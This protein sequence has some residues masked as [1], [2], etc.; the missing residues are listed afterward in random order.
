MTLAIEVRSA[1]VLRM[2]RRLLLLIALAACG[3]GA[4]TPAMPRSGTNATAHKAAV[5]AQLQPFID[6]EVVSSVV[7]GLYDAGKREVYGFGKGPSG[8]APTG[9]T[10]YE[11][12]S[13]TKVY[14]AL[15]LADAI[16]KRELALDTPLA[17]L[18]PPGV[19]A[20]SKDGEVIRMIHL[21]MHASSLPRIPASMPPTAAD[22]YAR[23]TEDLLYNDLNHLEL[24]VAPGR[25]VSYSNFGYGVLGFVLGRKLGSTYTKVLTDRV[26]TPLGLKNTFVVAP[27]GLPDRAQGTTDDLTPAPYWTWDAL[28]GAGA[29]ISTANDQL[30]LIDAEL[31]AFAGGKL[32]LRA[33][34]RLSQE[35]QS[36]EPNG[37][38]ASLG[39]QI[40]REGR[41]WHNGGTGGFRTFITFDPKTRRG[42][43]VLA[44]TA[45]T[46]VDR[47]AGNLYKVLEGEAPK[48]PV[49]PT[50][51][52]LAAIAGTYDFAGTKIQVI[53]DGK[54]L[55]IEGPGEP[56]HRMMPL[57]E[58]EFFVEA[59][60]APVVF[61]REAGKV[62]RMIFV[63]GEKTMT[64]QRVE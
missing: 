18:L 20:P 2:S 5:A 33:P 64:A 21:A 35:P 14:T 27:P 44:S 52:Q 47:I 34:M 45:T 30:T 12:G 48:P 38:G 17:D 13:I 26:L 40:D 8:V 54:R 39:W 55:Y 28:A 6:H 37:P 60:Q 42:I 23:Y 1:T 46:L 32:P 9:D 36:Q 31:D 58:R 63:L 56:R 49:F 57:T 53:A 62:K 22:P 15:L 41:Y 10:H 16:Q 51:A 3:G 4:V 7:V 59:I 43:V 61:E 11:L 50:V 25:V 19:T 29:L 24:P